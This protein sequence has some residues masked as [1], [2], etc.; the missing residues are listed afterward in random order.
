MLIPRV[1]VPVVLVMLIAVKPVVAEEFVI[2]ELMTIGPVAFIVRMPVPAQVIAELALTVIAVPPVRVKL[3][4]VQDSPP[5][6]PPAPVIAFAIVIE[7][8]PVPV[9][10]ASIATLPALKLVIKLGMLMVELANP[11]KS[12]AP[13]ANELPASAPVEI[14]TA[15]PG[16]RK[17]RPFFPNGAFVETTAFGLKVPGLEIS[18]NPPSPPFGPPSAVIWP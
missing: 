11:V 17:R 14:V 5:A 12:Y 16:S 15:Q 4:F 9:A 3:L 10:V 13:A 2:F 1:A 6:P 18:T 7:A 8:V